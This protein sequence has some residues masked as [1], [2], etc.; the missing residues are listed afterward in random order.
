MLQQTLPYPCGEILPHSK[1]HPELHRATAH[2]RSAVAALDSHPTRTRK[3]L[4]STSLGKS[5]GRMTVRFEAEEDKE[6]VA[7]LVTPRIDSPLECD[8]V[9]SALR[10]SCS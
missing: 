1:L 7:A 10:Q 5:R 2:E 6:A 3:L 9:M 8:L 4:G